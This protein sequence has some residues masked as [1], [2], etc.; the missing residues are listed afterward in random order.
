MGQA[1]DELQLGYVKFEVLLVIQVT[2]R[3]C[4][5]VFEHMDPESILPWFES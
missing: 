4:D 2:E 3:K 1:E 5:I